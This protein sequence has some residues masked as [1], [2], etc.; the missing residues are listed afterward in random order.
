M[1]DGA[2]IHDLGF[3]PYDGERR[4]PHAAVW[5]L[6]LHAAQRVL[7][8]KRQARH[9]VLP[10]IVIVIA[11]VP[12]LVFVGIAA[13]VPSGSLSAD[14]LPSYGEYLGFTTMALVLFT[15]F[16]APEAL[17]TD[18]RTGMLSLYLAAP[19]TRTTYVAAK[20]GA[21]AGVLTVIT[22]GPQLLMLVAYTLEGSGP[23]D[24]VEFAELLV[25]IVVTG[26]GVALLFGSFALAIASLT[27]RRGVASASVVLALLVSAVVTGTLVEDAGAPHA[28]S[29]FNLVEL[30]FQFGWRVHGDPLETGGMWEVPTAAVV[31]ATLGWT[32]AATG[33]T[34]WRYRRIEVTR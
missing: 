12:A 31:A 10:V 27:P 32:A 28:L 25:R 13:F 9:K 11:F 17:C 16:V 22:M 2:R 15:S 34:T 6:G 30:G 29:L 33:F 14:F 26:V 21:V 24:P 19:L 18:R 1:S 3:R 8:L 4:G 7:G 5:H 23:D 20:L